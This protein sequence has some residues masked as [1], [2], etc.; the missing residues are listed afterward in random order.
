MLDVSDRLKPF[1]NYITPSVLVGT[2]SAYEMGLA[3]ILSLHDSIHIDV[4]DG[5]FTPDTTYPYSDV[6]KYDMAEHGVIPQGIFTEAHLMVLDPFQIGCEY[7]RKGVTRL[8]AHREVFE[9][10]EDVLK[11]FDM[12]QSRGAE[13]ALSILF[14]TPI[15]T[16]LSLAR[17]PLVKHIQLMSISPIGVQGTLFDPRTLE[18]IKLLRSAVPECVITIDGGMNRDTICPV[19]RAGANRCVIGSAIIKQQDPVRAYEGLLKALVVCA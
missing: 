8:I 1:R 10:D 15:E 9:S 4:C 16:I 5:V 13:S 7:A 17:H 19:L 6:A 2:K 14:E 12:W 3:T 11:T 18:K